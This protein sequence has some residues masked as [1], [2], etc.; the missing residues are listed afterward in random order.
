MDQADG[1]RLLVKRQICLDKVK[2]IQVE[3]RLAIIAGEYKEVDMLI[4][5]LDQAQIELETTYLT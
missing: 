3:L 2:A 4:A 1:L 5:L